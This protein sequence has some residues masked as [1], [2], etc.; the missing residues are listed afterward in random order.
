MP[1]LAR[2]VEDP[3]PFV[4]ANAAI[5]LAQIGHENGVPHLERLARD[6][7]PRVAKIGQDAL[8]LLKGTL[9]Q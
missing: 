4:R 9:R 5:A 8:A 2:L 3:I 6:G 1:H 7:V